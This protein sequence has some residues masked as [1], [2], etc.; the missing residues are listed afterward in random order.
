MNET[1]W[2]RSIAHRYDVGTRG[3]STVVRLGRPGKSIAH[4]RRPDV[5]GGVGQRPVTR[6]PFP[7]VRHFQFVKNPRH[8]PLETSLITRGRPSITYYP[9]LRRCQSE[10]ADAVVTASLAEAR[11]ENKP[12]RD[13]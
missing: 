2:N 11:R 7:D 4:R 5:A 8:P 3:S 12:L 13:R 6:L 1:G 9:L 10:R